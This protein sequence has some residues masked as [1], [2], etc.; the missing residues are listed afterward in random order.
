MP[1]LLETVVK[2]VPGI[3]D[4]RSMAERIV[5]EKVQINPKLEESLFVKPQ[6]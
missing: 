1:Y 2:A 5:I 4:P 3:K 6:I